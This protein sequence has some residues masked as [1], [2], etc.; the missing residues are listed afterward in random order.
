MPPKVPAGRCGLVLSGG[1]LR[2]AFQVGVI[3]ALHGDGIHFDFVV[4]VSSGAWNAACV[5]AGQIRHMRRWWVQ[6]AAPPKFS[7]RNL[8]RN[9]P[10]LNYRTIVNTIPAAAVR[11]DRLPGSRVRLCIGA[12][13]IRDWTFRLFEGARSGRDFFRIVMA[14]NYLPG[15]YGGPV[16]IEG[17]YYADGGLTDDVPYE[18]ALRV[19]CERGLV[20]VPDAGG[21][22]R[23]RL[24]ARSPHQSEPE[25]RNRVTVIHPAHSLPVGRV[26]ATPA[27]VRACVEMGRTAAAEWLVAQS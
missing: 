17:R 8:W 22:T 12:T 25:M 1:F 16:R 26:R 4:G 10:P 27:A 9:R 23:K 13:R 3:E 11:F 20:V 6:G 24:F 7:L 14:S 19:G 18:A 5:A 21:P 2:S 15:I